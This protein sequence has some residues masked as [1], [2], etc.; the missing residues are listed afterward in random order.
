MSAQSCVKIWL[1]QNLKSMVIEVRER[2]T[3]VKTKEVDN[4]GGRGQ[5]GWGQTYRT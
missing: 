3:D 5:A 1:F 2:I 4:P